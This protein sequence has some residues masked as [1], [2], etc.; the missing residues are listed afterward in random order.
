MTD[1]EGSGGLLSGGGRFFAAGAVRMAQ[2]S[3]F[4]KPETPRSSGNCPRA[5]GGF[6]FLPV[7]RPK[8]KTGNHKNVRFTGEPG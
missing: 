5:G 2:L 6:P 3:D 4:D 8:E 1:A 7:T